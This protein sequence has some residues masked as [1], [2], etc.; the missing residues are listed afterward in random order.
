VLVLALTTTARVGL[1]IAAGAVVLI[2]LD[3][4]A[5]A[6]G[7]GR[8]YPFW[9]LFIAGLFVGFPLV[10]LAVVVGEGPRRRPPMSAEPQDSTAVYPPPRR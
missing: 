4:A 2:A 8:G 6:Y 10:L 1:I 7:R 5:A 3:G 9:P